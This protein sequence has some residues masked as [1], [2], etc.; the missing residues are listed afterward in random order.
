MINT[1]LLQAHMVLNGVNAKDLA[2]AQGWSVRNAYRKIKGET[3]F[4]VP[5]VQICKDLLHLDP[6]TANAIFL[7]PIC[8]KRQKCGHR[9]PKPLLQERILCL[10]D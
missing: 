10:T 8:P 5:E 4:T 7:P 2:D 9:S 3:A 1:R 6:P